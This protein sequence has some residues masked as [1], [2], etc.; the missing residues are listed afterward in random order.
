MYISCLNV[1]HMILPHIVSERT[2]VHVYKHHAIIHCHPTL[3]TI[4]LAILRLN[5]FY[6]NWRRGKSEFFCSSIYYKD[7]STATMGSTQLEN[8]DIEDIQGVED[9]HIRFEQYCITNPKVETSNKTAFYLTF[10]GKK[11]FRLLRDLAY[12]NDITKMDV[13]Q[14]STLLL[15]HLQPVHYEAAERER[16]Y[17]ITRRPEEALRSFVLRIQQQ[18][19][20]CN[21]GASLEEQ[22]RDR[23][24]AGVA[25]QEIKRKLLRESPLTFTTAKA[26]LE[27]WTDINASLQQPAQVFYNQ[28]GVGKHKQ[29]K[30]PSFN[31]GR[32]HRQQHKPHNNSSHT[33]SFGK[34]G[35]CNSCGGQHERRTCKF[36]QA[37]CHACRRTGH[38]SRVCRSKPT[39]VRAIHK[40]QESDT[41]VNSFMVASK[42]EHL[43]HTVVFSNGRR[44]DFIIDTGSPISILPLNE[45]KR[46]G[47]K[48]DTIRKCSTV[49]KGVSGH[50][51]TVVG[52]FNTTA[53]SDNGPIPLTFVLTE[54]GPSVL[55]LD[56]LRALNVQLVLQSS[57]SR[58]TPTPLPIEVKELVVRCGRS[59]GGLKIQPVHLETTGHPIFMRARPLAYGLRAAVKTSLDN[60]VQDGVLEPVRTSSWA[61]PIVTVMKSNGQPRICG[62]YRVTV[63]PQLLQT[64]TTT[65]DVD[66]MFEGLHG[67]RFFS[68]L[69]LSN[70]FLQIPL[71]EP[72]S[73]LTTINTMWGLY[74]YRYLPFGLKVSPG[75]FQAAIDTVISGVPG[76]RAYQ[77]DIIVVGT[78]RQQHDDNLLR[79]LRALHSHNA[80]INPKKS[81]FAVQELKYLGYCVDADGIS[82]D[83]DRIQAL[84]RAPKP[85][86]VDQLRS[87]LGF[88]QYYAKFVPRFAHKAE[89]LYDL[90]KDFNW[91]ELQ[92]KAYDDLLQALCD[93][94]V[95]KSFQIGVPSQLIV[96]ASEYA[97]GAVLEQAGHPIICVSRK[98]SAA[99]RNYSQTQREALAIHWGVQRLHKYLYGNKFVIITDH[100][101]LQY[102]LHPESSLGKAT[103]AMIQ[104]WA[105]HLAA[106]QYEIVHRAGKEIPH[107]DFLSRNAYQEEAHDPD[108]TT[109]LLTNP[110]PITRNHL[111]E[112]TR[113]A[114]GPVAAALR[115]GWSLSA[116]KTFPE[117]YSRR[118]DLHIQA[119]G[120][121][122]FNDRN[123]IPPSCRLP[124]LQH[125]HAGHLG[126]DKMVSLSRMLCWWP[127]INADINS[128]I[129]D[130][131]HC[132][133]HKP[134]THPTWTPWP[135]TYRPMQRIHADY[136]GPFLGR[137][138]ALVVEDAYSKFPE[139][140]LTTSA[141]AAF[142]KRAL[143]SFFAREG[144]A[145]VLVT[146][147]GT[148]FTQQDLQDWLRKIGC[149][150]L[151]TA[152]RHPQSNGQAENFVR[153]LKTAIRTI[154]PTSLEDLQ[155]GIDNFLLQ[156]RNAAHS[157]TRKSP[158]LL[159]K[160]RNLRSSM[161]L[162]T[163]EVTFFRGN[164]ARP[165][166]GLV[167]NRLGNRMF[168]IMDREDG[169]V[170]RRHRDQVTLSTPKTEGDVV[171]SKPSA[172]EQQQQEV[173]PQPPDSPDPAPSPEAVNTQLDPAPRRS[174][175]SR[176]PPV[177]F[178][179][180]ELT[181]RS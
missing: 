173:P 104:R 63:N 20:K 163:T 59:E 98:L 117:L 178:R 132:S 1:G 35:S 161:S 147:N 95:L 28:Q 29:N 137:Y 80:L 85:K 18:A 144:I 148:H 75:I 54:A 146:D 125:L 129:R 43:Y 119:D 41:E 181:G 38:I 177:R 153:S 127:T 17:N 136:C 14:L 76:V 72:S 103:S 97:V 31:N 157:T 114:Y 130:C 27:Q 7:V 58:T 111:L 83:H 134:R 108:D 101:A 89:P 160:G 9:W 26:I 106:Y 52:E 2:F 154:S 92:D 113:L 171:T 140:F 55:G 36:R 151:F 47:F 51:L 48:D 150:T 50:S 84:R 155:T 78:T 57:T 42:T 44:K 19:A 10:V 79:L 180:F 158:A 16:F 71:D 40:S 115:R 167:L 165:C 126:R 131:S 175:R 128:F 91:S 68:K 120:A 179:D 5:S 143:Q 124:L 170:H 82:A 107:A 94:K 152:P 172:E 86:S 138:W 61:T 141:T 23:I 135:V 65:L 22:M 162:D 109:V 32:G 156:Y 49:I 64:A 25:D 121:I 116:R 99:E 70:A 3:V 13:G 174:Q 142:T 139:V 77:D 11:A 33:P 110:L 112:E 34:L 69:D 56:G 81:V 67:N 90:L 87:F 15:D 105:L 166:D 53:R 8:L 176:R 60:L 122:I 145:Q 4:Q 24:I 74:K 12:P 100:K 168:S 6:N 39:E 93:G 169:S 164:D 73:Q 96:D 123:V 62:D 46:L 118:A 21:F 102:L 159:F 66:S 88:A 37:D 30:R 149:N 45:F 133:I